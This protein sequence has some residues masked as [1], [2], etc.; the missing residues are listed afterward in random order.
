MNIKDYSP[1]VNNTEIE[2]E[3]NKTMIECVLENFNSS[4]PDL[5]KPDEVEKAING[6]FNNCISKGLKPGN[7][8]LYN[9]LDL[10]KT[11]VSD[12]LHGRNPLKASVESIRLIKKACKAM[13]EYRE[14]LGSQNK[15]PVPTLIFWQKN[16]DG[17]E[18]VQRMEIAADNTPKADLSPDEIKAQIEQDIPL[19][20]DYNEID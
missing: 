2:Y 8:G 9:A 18:D 15:L 19:D 5:H 6:Y 17:L 16:Y 4:K 13:S 3:L 7:L 1:M 20:V 11:E 14:M 12:L 10:T